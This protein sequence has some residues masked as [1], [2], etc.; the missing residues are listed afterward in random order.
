MM[1]PQA[2]RY[3]DWVIAAFNADNLDEFVREQMAGDLLARIR[4]RTPSTIATGFL[5]VGARPQ[6]PES[7]AIRA[8]PG[9]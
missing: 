7:P 6:Y 4:P 5:A 2:W 1:Y 9:R 3:R 8:R